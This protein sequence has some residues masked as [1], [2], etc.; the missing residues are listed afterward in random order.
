MAPPPGHM[1][2]M[3]PGQYMPPGPMGH[4]QEMA[5]LQQQLQ[6]FYCMPQQTQDIQAKVFTFSQLILIT[7]FVLLFED[8]CEKIS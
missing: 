4:Q 6:E 3:H 1:M 5:A 7:F 8:I 2:E